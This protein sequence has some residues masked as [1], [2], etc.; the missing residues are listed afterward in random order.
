MK[1]E[2][3]GDEAVFKIS[4]AKISIG[5]IINQE[6]NQRDVKGQKEE[7]KEDKRKTGVNQ[8]GISEW[9]APIKCK[10]L[11]CVLLFCG[12]HPTPHAF[13]LTIRLGS[14][15]HCDTIWPP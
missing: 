14:R 7:G 9:S 13:S 15:S 8:V 11:N 3:D 12:M 5:K 6:A 4:S 10:G 1:D 2:K